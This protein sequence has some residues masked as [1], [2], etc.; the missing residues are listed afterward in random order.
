[1]ASIDKELISNKTS[2][3]IFDIDGCLADIE[4]I[5]LTYKESYSK[6]L[7]EYEKNKEKY[8]KDLK[9][10]QYEL[11]QINNKLSVNKDLVEPIEPKVPQMYEDKLKDKI[12]FAYFYSHIEEALPIGGIVDT[13]VALALTKK[14]IILTGRDE[15][16]KGST[17]DWLRKVISKR[18]NDDTYRRIN[19]STI[20]KP[21][22]NNDTTEKYKK[23]KVNELAKQYNIQLIIEDCPAIIEE[24]T[25]LGFLVLSPN[26]EN[27][28][29]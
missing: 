26:K 14:V 3:Y 6:K 1:M 23:D 29:V 5:L 2:I 11:E 16:Y 4:N 9:I 28:Y 13:F 10:Y 21:T 27:K 25:K 17:I 15:M 18:F 7:E 12:D 19:F 22:K 24:F 20:F 8:N